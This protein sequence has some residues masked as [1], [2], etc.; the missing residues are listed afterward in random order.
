MKIKTGHNSEIELSLAVLAFIPRP[1]LV[2]LNYQ[3]PFLNIER[4]H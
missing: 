3:L 1:L 2:P 4:P